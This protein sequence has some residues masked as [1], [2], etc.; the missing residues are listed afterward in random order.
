MAAAAPNDH[1]ELQ[2]ADPGATSIAGPLPTVVA[3]RVIGQDPAIADETGKI[4]T[5]NASVR[6]STSVGPRSGTGSGPTSMRSGGP[7]SVT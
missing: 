4:L 2:P 3:L 6:T 1:D 7:S 5:A